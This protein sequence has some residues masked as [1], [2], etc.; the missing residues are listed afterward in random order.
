MLRSL[1]SGVGTR[2]AHLRAGLCLLALLVSVPKTADGSAWDEQPG[3][4]QLILTSSYLET[5][6][7]FDSQWDSHVFAYDGSY[8][9]F[10]LN[11]Y[12]DVGLRRRWDLV[13]NVPFL[14]LR[15]SND[16]GCQKSA[17]AGDIAVGLKYRLNSLES[18]WAVSAQVITQ[19]PAYSA[20]TD[21]A[22]GNHQEDIEARFLLGR[23]GKWAGRHVFWDAETAYRYRTGAPA[24]QFRGD[25]TGGMDVTSRWMLMAQIFTITS[26]QN[27]SAFASTNPNAQSDFDLYKGQGSAVLRVTPKLRVQAGWT[28]A[29]AGRNTGRDHTVTLGIWKDF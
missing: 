21:P 24:D 11:A 3:H 14:F 5:S 17:G 7:S 29:F 20:T 12:L 1:P 25:F 9:Q 16:Y 8:R 18:P 6:R 22:L 27:G 13:A 23:G 26:M 2:A 19:F 10:Q 28:Y 15:F 4:G